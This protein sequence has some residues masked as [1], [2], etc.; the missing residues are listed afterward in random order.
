M[1]E[2]FFSDNELPELRSR[3]RRLL[4]AFE[5]NVSPDDVRGIREAIGQAAATGVLARDRFG[6]NAVLSSMSTAIAL[7]DSVDA[8]RNMV[9][10][11]LLSPVSRAG[12]ITPDAIARRWGD[13]VAAL[14]RGI[15]KVSSLYSRSTS[16]ESENFR[17][18][19]LTFAEDIRVI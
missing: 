12:A 15:D 13:D 18:L 8:D 6:F 3:H 16:V 1:G 10:A 2:N 4:K 5:G 17:K 14:V 9:L 19:L 11:I 7:C